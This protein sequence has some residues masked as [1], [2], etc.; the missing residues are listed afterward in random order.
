MEELRQ[1][2]LSMDRLEESSVYKAGPGCADCKQTGYRGRLGIHELLVVDDDVRNLIMRAADS[3]SIRR[4]A[5]SKGM[6]TLRED[7]AEKLLKGQTTVEEILR[8]TQDDLGL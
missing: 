1:L 5:A 8:V 6:T 3:S 7:G 4:A 2:G